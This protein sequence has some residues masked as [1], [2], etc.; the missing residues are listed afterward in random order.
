V[1]LASKFEKSANYIFENFWGKKGTE[2]C[3]ISNE[4]AKLKSAQNSTYFDAYEA[5]MI[6]TLKILRYQIT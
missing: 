6:F 4:F 5:Y 3:K 1:H 2:R